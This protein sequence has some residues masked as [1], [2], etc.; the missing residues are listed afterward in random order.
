VV[1]QEAHQPPLVGEIGAQVRSHR[2]RVLVQQAVVQPFVVA[3]VES[4]LLQRPLEV[5][6][7][8]RDEQ[9]RKADLTS[10]GGGS[11]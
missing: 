2:V 5:P 7:R 1:L 6:V 10:G 4:L 8:L 9:Y 3:V 11:G